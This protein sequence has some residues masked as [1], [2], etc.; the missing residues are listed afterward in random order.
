MGRALRARVP[1]EGTL[2]GG[3]IR[4]TTMKRYLSA[5]LNHLI[6]FV[7][8]HCTTEPVTIREIDDAL[9]VYV[10]SSF[11]SG[12]PLYRVVY[13]IVSL[14]HTQPHVYA[15]IT[16]TRYLLRTW[17]KKHEGEVVHYQPLPIMILFAAMTVLIVEGEIGGAVG[18]GIGFSALLRLNELGRIKVGDLILPESVRGAQA[19]WITIALGDTKT[20][21]NDSVKLDD[22]IMSQVLR[23]Y[24]SILKKRLGGVL[25]RGGRLF[26]QNPHL[27]QIFKRTM[28]KLGVGNQGY[29][30][31]SLRTGGACHRVLGGEEI[32][33][34]IE[35]GRWKIRESAEAY[36]QQLRCLLA[37][38]HIEDVLDSGWS[39]MMV[40]P[41][42][43]LCGLMKR[44]HK[45][46]SLGLF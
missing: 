33:S 1:R 3:A 4:E 39:E 13:A 30:L 41:S 35:R 44:E 2:V 16:N 27:C 46:A 32:G 15:R 31:R 28:E 40:D 11:E 26:P 17:E 25:P 24:L 10:E 22:P 19:R 38:Q 34:L 18:L 20:R 43:W 8:K 42:G 37:A 29:V 6:P 5:F 9:A 45:K 36:L 21:R 7:T 14:K 12:E 23:T